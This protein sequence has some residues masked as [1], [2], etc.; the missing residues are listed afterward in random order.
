MSRQI[1]HGTR[2]GNDGCGYGRAQTFGCSACGRCCCYCFGADNTGD[3]FHA[4]ELCDDCW[5]AARMQ[6]ELDELVEDLED[7]SIDDVFDDALTAVIDGWSV[8]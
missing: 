2:G 1:V 8:E 7:E 6:L 3:A 5:G 4:R